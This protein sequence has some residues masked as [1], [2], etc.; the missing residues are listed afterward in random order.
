MLQLMKIH[1]EWNVSQCTTS[2]MHHL[3]KWNRSR[4][5]VYSWASQTGNMPEA[6]K[7]AGWATDEVGSYEITGIRSFFSDPQPLTL[8]YDST[9]SWPGVLKAAMVNEVGLTFSWPWLGEKDINKLG[10]GKDGGRKLSVGVRQGPGG[11]SIRPPKLHL[12]LERTDLASV[13]D[14]SWNFS[15]YKSNTCSL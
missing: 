9:N 2:L 7:R 11:Q 10:G 3:T 12:G 13:T 8:S 4:L 6:Q 1:N 15:Y 5:S 14:A